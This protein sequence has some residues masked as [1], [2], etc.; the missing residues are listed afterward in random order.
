MKRKFKEG[1]KTI[2]SYIAAGG[3]GS[4]AGY[5][6]SLYERT[7]AAANV[8]VRPELAN[9]SWW[10][11]L[12]ANHLNDWLWYHYGNELTISSIITGAFILLTVYE[13]YRR[14]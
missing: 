14:W 8:K 9:V 7:S 13:L 6:Y 3:V 2:A 10:E 4:L 11:A 12:L 5:I 1:I